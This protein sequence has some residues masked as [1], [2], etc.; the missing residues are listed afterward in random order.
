MKSTMPDDDLGVGMI[1][2]HGRDV[3]GDSSV[4]DRSGA[5]RT[6]HPFAELAASAERLASGLRGLGVRAGDRVATVCWNHHRHAAAY[7]AVPSMG[8]VLHTVNLRLGSDELAY[9]LH[10]AEDR[11][12]IADG[13]LLPILAAKPE[14]LDGVRMLVVIGRPEADVAV[15]TVD[16]DEL[17]ASAD[18]TFPWP[19]VD[20]RS[21]ATLCYTSGT[22]GRPKGVAYSHRS[23]FLHTLAQCSA[24]TFGIGERDRVLMVVPMFH[25][26]AWGLPY[27]C[28]LTGA[29]MLMPGSDLSAAALADAI[30]EEQATFFAAVPTIVHDL[31]RHTAASGADVSSVRVVISGGSAVPPALIEQVRAHWGVRLVQGWGMTE[32]SPLAALSFPPKSVPIAEEAAWLVKSGR[33]VAGLEAR[34]VGQDGEPL[35]R[36]GRSI[37]E[38]QVRGPWVTAAYHAIDAAE[39]FQD[40][41]LRTGD[42]GSIDEHGYIVIADRTK[43]MIKSGGEWISSVQLENVLLDHSDVVEAA[44]VAVADERWQERPLAIV[45]AEP[46]GDLEA[47]PDELRAH[48]ARSLPSWQIPDR[49]LF[50]DALPRTGVGKIDKRSLRDRFAGTDP[51]QAATTEEDNR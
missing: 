30:A 10:H 31:L 34:V 7:L 19:D 17:V 32:T 9:L 37:G 13:S 6:Q 44:V 20:E 48:L 50:V 42:T 1:L 43:D 18:P 27:S 25:A 41:W 2:Q 14:I 51:V 24:N 35:D 33:I 23:M 36:D 46:G 8:A 11:V 12:V 39:S 21:A 4:V 26:N 5:T 22:T 45:V 47:R 3:Y 16:F 38:L 29:D 49:F 28:F 15:P 40:G